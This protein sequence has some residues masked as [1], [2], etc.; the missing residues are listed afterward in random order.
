M[1][2]LPQFD[3]DLAKERQEAE[4]A[5]EVSFFTCVDN[6]PDS[7]LMVIYLPY[8]NKIKDDRNLI[9]LNDLIER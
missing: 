4:E 1:Q 2:K 6:L 8:L 9:C 7:L 3:K 5:G